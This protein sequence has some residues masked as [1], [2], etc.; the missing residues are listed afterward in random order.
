MRERCLDAC[1]FVFRCGL[2]LKCGR[3]VWG[4]ITWCTGGGSVG[5]W[6]EG[7]DE[8]GFWGGRGGV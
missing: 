1:V 2:V 6:G 5:V 7:V 4:I 3:G 8:R